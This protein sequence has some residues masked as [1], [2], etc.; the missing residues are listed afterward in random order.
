MEVIFALIAVAVIS[1]LS[2][3]GLITIAFSTNLI[4]RGTFIL[5]SLAVGVLLGDVFFH[6]LPTLE[7]SEIS[8][9][10]MVMVGILGFFVLE[11]VLHWHHH[12]V[13]SDMHAENRAAGI[14]NL[15]ADGLHNF[16]DG[17]IIASAFLID[18]QLGV[19][20]TVAV[21]LHEIPQEIADFGVLLHAGFTRTEALVWNFVSA[22]S[23]VIGVVV[24]VLF[25]ENVDSFAPLMTAFAA[26]AF[27]YIAMADLIPSLHQHSKQKVSNQVIQVVMI[28]IGIM[29]MLG[30]TQVESITGVHT[31]L[32]SDSHE[33][34]DDHDHDDDHDDDDH[35]LEALQE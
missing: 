7:L 14:N 1:L 27:I 30:L 15:V 4:K 19:A 35:A 31:H 25:S 20:T 24:G 28:L 10:L 9:S 17:L 29:L 32:H 22:L 2:L 11:K 13:E 26:G 33:L 18:T 21:A 23:A 8:V 16:V 34:L 3:V 12:H 5:V 6:I